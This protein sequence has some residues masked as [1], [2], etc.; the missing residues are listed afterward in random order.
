MMNTTF[1]SSRHREYPVT[2]FSSVYTD[3]NG[4]TWHVYNDVAGHPVWADVDADY[5]TPRVYPSYHAARTEA[6][7]MAHFYTARYR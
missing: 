3:N 5:P 2:R 4:A 1:T 6:R 7:E